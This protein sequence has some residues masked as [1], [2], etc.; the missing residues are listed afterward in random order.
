MYFKGDQW[1]RQHL[2]RKLDIND[3]A[4]SGMDCRQVS[5]SAGQKW[6]LNVSLIFLCMQ[7]YYIYLYTSNSK[8]FA[9]LF[10]STWPCDPTWLQLT[11][12]ILS[13]R[14]SGTGNW[15][16]AVYKHTLCLWMHLLEPRNKRLLLV[17]ACLP[18][19]WPP[20][21]SADS[22][23]WWGS[24]ACRWLWRPRPCHSSCAFLFRR[25]DLIKETRITVFISQTF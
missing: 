23:V 11:P 6:N 9:W 4:T 16:M 19:V 2:L 21:S 7:V 8:V 5:P 10:V 20:R 13:S 24:A 25:W 17:C 22:L 15:W 14:R 3:T 1:S 12:L 18:A